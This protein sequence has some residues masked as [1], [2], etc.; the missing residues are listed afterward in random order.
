LGPYA[1]PSDAL[2]LF[3]AMGDLAHRKIFPA[4]LWRQPFE[5]LNLEKD[6]VII[7]KDP[8]EDGNWGNLVIKRGL[9]R[10]AASACSKSIRNR[11]RFSKP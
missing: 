9:K 5:M 2:I 11:S 8:D 6:C 1:Q 10:R 7:R 4:Q 3:G